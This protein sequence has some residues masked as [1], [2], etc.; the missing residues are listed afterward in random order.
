MVRRPVPTEAEVYRAVAVVNAPIT[1]RDAEGNGR[2]GGVV[3]LAVG[4]VVDGGVGGNRVDLRGDRVG[5][6]PRS[7]GRRANEPDTLE[8]DVV[9]VVL[10]FD[11]V[12]GGVHR[13]REI[14]AVDGLE[15]R[16]ARVGNINGGLG[17][18]DDSLLWDA[19]ENDRLLRLW[20]PRNRVANIGELMIGG[21]LRKAVG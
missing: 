1:R 11:D 13:V 3:Y 10:H 8:V 2:R 20:R 6:G 4:R 7:G 19:G 18:L 12:E 14:R 15:L 21:D 9:F 16:I 5:H 17:A